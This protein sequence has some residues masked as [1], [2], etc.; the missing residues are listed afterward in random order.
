MAD[1]HENSFLLLSEMNNL[2]LHI[3]PLPLLVGFQCK[4]HNGQTDMIEKLYIGCYKKSL[5]LHCPSSTDTLVFFT[6]L[7]N[8]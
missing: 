6:S 4:K 3:S 2:I 1:R 8:F 7:Q 5:S